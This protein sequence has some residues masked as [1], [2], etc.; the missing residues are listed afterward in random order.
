MTVYKLAWT[1]DIHLNFC[2]P[3]KFGYWCDNINSLDIDCLVITG[4]IAEGNIIQR[5]MERLQ[6]EI[7]VPIHFVLGNHDY[8]KSGIGDVRKMLNISFNAADPLSA[9]WLGSTPYIHLTDGVALVGHDGW[10]DGL[11]ADWMKSN[12]VLADYHVIYD[13][14]PLHSGALLGKMRELSQESAEH[15]ASGL[16]KAI[17]DGHR[18]LFIAT[19]V[20]PWKENSVY[21]GKISDD[22]WLPHFSSKLMGDAILEVAKQNPE[23]KFTVMC[24]HSHGKAEF[25]PL[26]NVMS[27]TG[28][29]RYRRPN[30][31]KIFEIEDQKI[32]AVLSKTDIN[33]EVDGE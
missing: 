33:D 4:D 13:F 9:T 16:R 3:A 6:S 14:V 5:T 26:P 20:P 30:L 25:A 27:Y 2:H 17:D 31:N 1:T 22:H 32:V 11:Y 12:V 29:A 15:V 21:Q 7:T 28:E 19:H 18:C 24:G 8:Y 23:C 10:Y